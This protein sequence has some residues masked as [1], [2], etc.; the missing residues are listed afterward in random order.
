MLP[1]SERRPPQRPTDHQQPRL[2]GESGQGAPMPYTTILLAAALQ[3]WERYSLH[4]LAA[5]DVAATLA[6]GASTPL[7]VV[8]VYDH[9]PIDTV[10]LPPEIAIRHREDLMRRTDDLM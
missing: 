2:H 4:A 1:T 10:D 7:H 8:S 5:R 9:P 3:R 6:R